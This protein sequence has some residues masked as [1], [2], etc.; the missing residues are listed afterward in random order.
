[1]VLDA[2]CA[3]HCLDPYSVEFL[4]LD[5][6]LLVARGTLP[7]TGHAGTNRI[8]FQGQ[9]SRRTRLRLGRYTLLLSA[10]NTAG[11]RSRTSTLSFTIVK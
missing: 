7:L 11:Q 3:S 9:I 8:A 10:V 1:M 4:E 6:V 5:G 2:F